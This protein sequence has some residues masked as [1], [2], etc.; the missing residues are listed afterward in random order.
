MLLIFM[1]SSQ[2]TA[3]L[4]HMW[5]Q[6]SRRPTRNICVYNHLLD[7][8]KLNAQITYR[9]KL[10]R[11]EMSNFDRTHLCLP[12]IY[13]SSVPKVKIMKYN[14]QKIYFLCEGWNVYLANA[15]SHTLSS[16][17]IQYSSCWGKVPPPKCCDF[18]LF[19]YENVQN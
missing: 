19:F 9:R 6:S 2:Q 11:Q 14:T 16:C 18:P 7:R 5:I 12:N 3:Y 4:K 8:K 17:S 10:L 13:I 15:I 1:D